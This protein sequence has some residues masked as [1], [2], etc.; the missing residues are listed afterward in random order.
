MEGGRERGRRAIGRGSRLE[1]LLG[2]DRIN[3]KSGWLEIVA[4]VRSIC[5]GPTTMM[6]IA[7]EQSLA[8]ARNAKLHGAMCNKLA[9][10]VSNLAKPLP[11]LNAERH[12]WQKS[13][14]QA[15]CSLQMALEKSRALLQYCAH[16]SKLYLAIK[17]H[18]II[19]KFETLREELEESVRR[20]SILVPQH[21]ALQ[22]AGLETEIGKT[23]FVL[24]PEEK[25]MGA[26][27]IS[28]LLQKQ[29]GGQFENP[30][31][32]QESFLQ[33]GIRLA[34]TSAEGINLE[35][36]AL[37]RQLEKAQDKQDRK[38]EATIIHILYLIKKYNNVLQ[39]DVETDADIPSISSSSK[40]PLAPE[41]FR[42]P[43][44]LQL[45]SDPVIVASGQTYERVCIEKWFKEGHVTCPKTQ[46][47]LEHLNLTPNYC[48]KGLIAGWC[49]AHSVPVPGPP[50]APPSPVVSCRWDRSGS[51]AV[52]K[53][54]YVDSHPKQQQH[55]SSS[56]DLLCHSGGGQE[57][58]AASSREHL[59]PLH[60]MSSSMD[61]HDRRASYSSMN[62]SLNSSMNGR[63][64]DKEAEITEANSEE[65]TDGLAQLVENLKSRSWDI[66]CQAAEQIRLY[67]KNSAEARL[68]IGEGGAIPPLVDLLYNAIDLD[69]L[70]AQESCALALLNMAVNNDRNK[71]L[72]VMAGAVPLLVKMLRV[73]ETQTVKESAAAALLTLSCLND[74]KACIG[75][76]GAI[77][78]L[79]QLLISG[80]NQGRKDALTTLYNLTIFMGNRHR[81][82]RAGA[83]PILIHLLSLRKV[84][85]VEKCSALLYNLSFTDEGRI[86]I[87]QTDGAISTLAEILES[88]SVREKEHVAATLLLL[89]TNSSQL[90]DAV[91]K[92]GVIPALVAISVSGTP[93]ARDKA[94]K[95]LLHFREQ[96]Q[97]EAP[98]KSVHFNMYTNANT[99]ESQSEG[100]A[101][102]LRV[103][104]DDEDDP[105]DKFSSERARRLTKSRSSQLIRFSCRP[106]MC[107]LRC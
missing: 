6:E 74:N 21:L 105:S 78:L 71:A 45:M 91:L 44:S 50:S 7:V 98:C 70:R 68:V 2:T 59:Q 9:V 88:G 102:S 27:L 48:V 75:S 39:R 60:Q 80:S 38:K 104:H 101:D 83:I 25:Q 1:G 86:G 56:C 82:I 95:L 14:V 49:E 73:G 26:E 84:D 107:S 62:S 55:Q 67:T 43:I 106:R 18:S 96:R 63:P 58:S 81:V 31:A 28:L 15:F 29:K 54:E 53:G 99:E 87:A 77:P 65:V 57:L 76:F 64:D 100:E 3:R 97:K 41:E 4:V 85:L 66:Q 94:Q 46:Q 72:V 47:R 36:K 20:L 42:C 19:C 69:D 61:F 22:M 34:L 92:E 79:V 24:D 90:N 33:I 40:L 23:E 93:R 5:G 52:V 11:A 32:E 16:S 12:R 103:H 51:D 8:A 13:G 17:G 10:L 37:K 30:Q 89:C 35:R